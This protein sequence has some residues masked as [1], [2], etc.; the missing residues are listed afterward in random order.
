[1]RGVIQ[2]ASIGLALHLVL[3][4]IPGLERSLGLIVGTSHLLVG[5]AFVA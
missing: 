5:A 2:V 4:E 1:L 3:P